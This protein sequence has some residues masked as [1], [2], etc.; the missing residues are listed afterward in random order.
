M[1]YQ[2]KSVPAYAKA[3][4]AIIVVVALGALVG[5]A[6]R[7]SHEATVAKAQQFQAATAIQMAAREKKGSKLAAKE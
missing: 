4:I 3:I 1:Q 7:A 5:V 2:S 6:T